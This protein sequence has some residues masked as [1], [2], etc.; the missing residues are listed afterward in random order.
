MPVPPQRDIVS[1]VVAVCRSFNLHRDACPTS[2]F[3]L[4]CYEQF[5]WSFNLHR[6]ACPTS[7]PDK[8]F[9]NPVPG[10]FQS[11]PRCL[12]H[13]NVVRLLLLLLLI[14]GFNLHRDA[15][16]TSTLQANGLEGILHRFNLHRDACPTSTPDPDRDRD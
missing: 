13:L 15:C 14:P 8:R 2:T 12:S 9:S 6:D 3:R 16:P 7:T 11:P 4:A 5:H 10:G 1:H